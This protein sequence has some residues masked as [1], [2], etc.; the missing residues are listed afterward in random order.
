MT[1]NKFLPFAFI[2]FFLNSVGLPFGLTWM[3]LF[4]PFFYVWVLLTRKKEILL[5]FFAILL[6]FII[7]HIAFVGVEL[8]IYLVSLLNIVMVYIFCQA[9]YTFL[10]VC[11]DSE[12]IF[13]WLLITNFIFC[14]IGIVFYFTPWHELFWISQHLTKGVT[15]FKRFR[16]FSYEASYYATLFSPLFFFFLLQYLLRQNR[17]R[18]YKLLPMLFLPLILSFSLGVIGA[19]FLAFIFTAILHTRQLMVK[20]RVVNMVV[21]IGSVAVIAIMVLVFYFRHNPFFTRLLNIFSGQD[22]SAKGRTSDAFIL[23]RNML[24]D[25][26]EWWGIGVGQVKLQGHDLI[27]GYYLYNIDFV[28]SIPNG[29]A[30]MLAIFGWLGFGLK[31]FIEISLFFFTR[32]WTNYY[33]LLLFFFMFIYQFTGSFVTNLAEY[34]IWILAFTNV[35]AQFDVRSYRREATAASISSS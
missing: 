16:L 5:P 11:P 10:K 17:I 4:A 2:Y 35:F 18:G 22:T 21:N 1:I 34:V 29:M 27:Q 30:E 6:P 8:N 9:F 12:K 31:L 3:A 28:A 26:N 33:R 7:V 13:R 23:A 20:R 32:V 14:L 24:A 15:D 25:K 19:A